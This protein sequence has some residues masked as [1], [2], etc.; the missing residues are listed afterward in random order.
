MAVKRL[1]YQQRAVFYRKLRDLDQSL[2]VLGKCRE[3]VERNLFEGTKIRGGCVGQPFENQM[4]ALKSLEVVREG[5]RKLRAIGREIADVKQR[6]KD[7]LRAT[8]G[9]ERLFDIGRN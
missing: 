4:E 9:I 7:L 2:K 1:G 8:A 3:V 5:Y 6:R